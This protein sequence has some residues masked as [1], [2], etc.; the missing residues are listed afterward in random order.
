MELINT[1]IDYIARTNLFNFI[2]F[3]G[4]IIFLV[5]KLNV[6][7]KMEVAVNNIE[8]SI[9]DS[10]TAKTE[11][12]E[13]LS[14]VEESMSRLSEEIDAIIE[15]S[16]GNAKQVGEKIIEDTCNSVALIKENTQKTI[17]NNRITLKNDLVRRASLASV[18]VAKSY[19]IEELKRNPD[20]HNKLID[21]SIDAIEGTEI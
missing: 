6:K 12:K 10:E 4:I 5:K 2:I 21:E 1:I 7:S 11:S 8:T 16:E 14:A 19:I 20:L 15:Q 3:A 18:E 13:K 9:K 17:E